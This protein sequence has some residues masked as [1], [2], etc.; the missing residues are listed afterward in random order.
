MRMAHPTDI[1]VG[2]RL[3]LARLTKGLTQTE[4]GNLLNLSFQQVQKYESG[5]NRI[6]SSRLWDLAMILGVSISYFFD[7]LE[8]RDA[9][10]P[11]E[12]ISERAIRLAKEIDA[13]PDETTKRHFL[14]LI[15]SY[16]KRD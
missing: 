8:R 13:I 14:N 9:S 2:R 7:G 5:K 3:R 4:L 10:P 12:E 6:G 16:R 11:L 1:Y 15:R